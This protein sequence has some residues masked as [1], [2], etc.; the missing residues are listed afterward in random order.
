MGSVNICDAPFRQSTQNR[1]K[2]KKPFDIQNTFGKIQF[3]LRKKAYC[4]LIV[5]DIKKETNP[6]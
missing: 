2:F 3:M 6:F 4:V 1:T 5:P